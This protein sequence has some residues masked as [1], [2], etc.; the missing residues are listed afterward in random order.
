[1]NER[2]AGNAQ[3]RSNTSAST[4]SDAAPKDI[5]RVRPGNEAHD[6]ADGKKNRKTVNAKHGKL[7]DMSGGVLTADWYI[8]FRGCVQAS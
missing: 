7:W 4:L 5:E 8:I 1:M 3:D 6:K 2:A